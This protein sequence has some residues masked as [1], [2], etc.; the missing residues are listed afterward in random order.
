[1]K[2]DLT[3]YGCIVRQAMAE[4][5][6]N[7]ERYT[8]TIKAINKN[9]IKF[10]WSYLSKHEEFVLTVRESDDEPYVL[11][12]FPHGLS[13]VCFLIGEASWCDAKTLEVGIY[14]S[15]IYAADKAHRLF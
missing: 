11:I 10:N 6:K 2:Y 3:K 5:R 9:S 14:K 12:E 7:D 8:W 4:N 13:K 1:M 15:I